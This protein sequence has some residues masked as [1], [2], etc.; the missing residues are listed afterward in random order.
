MG[1]ISKPQRAHARHRQAEVPTTHSPPPS[2]NDCVIEMDNLPTYPQACGISASTQPYE[3]PDPERGTDNTPAK[4]NPRARNA[5]SKYSQI[6]STQDNN[7]PL[8][9]PKESTRA[10]IRKCWSRNWG[11][12]LILLFSGALSGIIAGICVALD[13]D[14]AKARADMLQYYA[15]RRNDS[16][17]YSNSSSCHGGHYRSSV[18]DIIW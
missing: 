10:R 13:K 15:Q 7:W 17:Y 2:N 4:K 14:S 6:P 8:N 3:S 11:W 18:I 16:C 1:L 5:G 9:P 12:C